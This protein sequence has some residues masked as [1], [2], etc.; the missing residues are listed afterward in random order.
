MSKVILQIQTTGE[1][2]KKLENFYRI[3]CADS[4]GATLR[5]AITEWSRKPDD[6]L[7]GNKTPKTSWSK[8]HKS[9]PV[10]TGEESVNCDVIVDR[11]LGEP[12]ELTAA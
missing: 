10:K 8:P 1:T 4:T 3:P 7:I 11:G 6:F 5:A 12:K 2:G 9:A